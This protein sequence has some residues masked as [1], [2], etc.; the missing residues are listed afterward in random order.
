MEMPL[1][2]KIIATIFGMLF[3]GF[4]VYF[5]FKLVKSW[6]AERKG[7]DPNLDL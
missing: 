3:A 4:G 5:S 2:Y 1:W 7:R 6:L